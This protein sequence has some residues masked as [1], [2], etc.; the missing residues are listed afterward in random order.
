MI[1]NG[2]RCCNWKPCGRKLNRALRILTAVT[3]LKWPSVMPENRYEMHLY[4]PWGSY[5]H[6]QQGQTE[7]LQDVSMHVYTMAH[8]ALTKR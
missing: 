5:C 2:R 6:I 1:H 7:A 3:M 8:I 4:G